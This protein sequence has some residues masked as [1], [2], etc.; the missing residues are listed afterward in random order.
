MTSCW[1]TVMH[2]SL[3]THRQRHGRGDRRGKAASRRLVRP[4][5]RGLLRLSRGGGAGGAWRRYR[6]LLLTGW[7]HVMLGWQ[8]VLRVRVGLLLMM[9]LLLVVV[10]LHLLELLQVL[11]LGVQ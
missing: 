5:R 1:I 3:W 9:L 6:G 2:L 11:E 10:L 8:L 4:M 7:G